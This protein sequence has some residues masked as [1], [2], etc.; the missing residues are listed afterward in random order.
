ME[1]REDISAAVLLL[2]AIPLAFIGGAI[3][4]LVRGINLNVSTGGGFAAGF[5]VSIMNGVLM[6]R[7]IP[8]LRLPGVSPMVPDGFLLSLFAFSLHLQRK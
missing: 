5:G 2:L 8:A 7:T 4:L 3:A 1:L 6:V